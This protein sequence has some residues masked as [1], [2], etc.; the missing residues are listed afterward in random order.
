MEVA[1]IQSL[2]RRL[3]GAAAAAR[4]LERARASRQGRRRR[5][6]PARDRRRN[7]RPLQPRLRRVPCNPQC[8]RA[9]VDA[10][11]PAH[12]PHRI[13][14]PAA[15]S[16]RRCASCR[17]RSATPCSR[18]IGFCRE[19]D[20]IADSGG[21]RPVRISQLGEWRDEINDLYQGKIG[22]KV[23]GL[24]DPVRKFGLKRED[25]LAVIDGMEMDAREDIRAPSFATLDLYCDRVASAV[26]RLSV[27]V[28]GIAEDDGMLLSH[29]LG[30]A[31]QLTN[32]LRDLD[33][34]AG[35]GRL[36]LPREALDQA[37]IATSD[38]LTALRSPNLS[39]ACA[40]L[41]ERART[42]FVEAD[43][44][45]ARCPRRTV[46]APR[47]MG[48]VYR[49]DPRRHGRAR[50]ERA[51]R[52][53]QRVRAPGSP[54]SSCATRSF[55]AAHRPHHR[56]RPR[57]PF[58]R[59]RAH[60]AR[61]ARRRARGDRRSPAAAAAPITM[62]VARHD[63]RQRQ[64]PAAVGQS[65]RASAISRSLGAEDRLVGPPKA[66]F[67]F[68]DLASR[69]QW[70]LRINDGRIPWWIF[71]SGKR[72]PGTRATRLPPAGA[73]AVGAERDRAVGEVVR[74]TGPLY[75]RLMRPLLLAALNIE[76]S[77]GS[78]AL[79][80]AIIRE[81]LALRR[82]GVPPAGRARGPR[83]R[84]DRARARL[85]ARAQQPGAARAPAPSPAQRPTRGSK[86][87]TSA[88]TTS[89]STSDDAVI[90]AVPPYA[91]AALVAGPQDAD[92]I[93]RHRQ[94]AFPHRAGAVPAAD[95]RADQQHHRMGVR[96]PGPGRDHHQRRRPPDRHAARRAGADDL[97]RG[98]RRDRPAG[99][100]A[101][102]ADR[103]RAAR[104]LCRDA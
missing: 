45:M 65:R 7:G 93:P 46:K 19:V 104:D 80:G 20:D 40:P 6:R 101:A 82:P 29:H 13:A 53:R 39:Q 94:R 48:E 78:A 1:V 36:Y 92:R 23:A 96:V 88:P 67:P 33:E 14:P 89:R 79:A 71:N 4:S 72:V 9:A 68:F 58:R 98:R 99:G 27:R 37:G 76:P 35:I 86:R 24:A 34:D 91:A 75:E 38:P 28:F 90:L 50:L 77:A 32:I 49:V 42:H 87:S 95:P 43:R 84:A 25:F 18:S 59:G 26:G 51:A 47:I 62:P 54:G 64:P 66:E 5:R 2:A 55:D 31:L 73:P 22:A 102:L 74:F 10:H 97:E 85:P 17:R 12:R 63:H 70:T 100:P 30:R 52:A 41:V 44:I 21:P 61:R 57:R 11:Q 103:A 60:A 83:Q 69:E 56:R 16:T 81:T 15:R 3:V 8:V